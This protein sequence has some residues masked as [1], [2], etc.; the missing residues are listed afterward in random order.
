MAVA[1]Q[2]HPGNQ[3]RS[4]SYLSTLSILINGDVQ[5]VILLERVNVA[6]PIKTLPSRRPPKTEINYN[7]LTPANFLSLYTIC[8][9]SSTLTLLDLRRNH[10]RPPCSLLAPLAPPRIP[11]PGAG[12]PLRT[13]TRTP[14]V[15]AP[16]ACQPDLP[17]IQR[18]HRCRGHANVC[19]LRTQLPRS[20]RPIRHLGLAS[21]TGPRPR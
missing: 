17:L 8:E 9:R 2:C 1:E 7:Y 12:H 16:P 18:S 10:G 19:P 15:D 13:I 11:A 3:T 20:D 14:P 21:T 4:K 6:V 5:I